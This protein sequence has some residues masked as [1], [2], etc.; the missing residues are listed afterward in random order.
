MDLSGVIAS[1]KTGTYTVTRASATDTYVAGRLAKGASTTLPVDA[2]VQPTEGR[3]LQKL[4]EGERTRESKTVFS[5]VELKGRAAGTRADV[6]TIN[7]DAYEIVKVQRW[8]ELGN[9][10]KAIALK[11]GD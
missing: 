10:W 1:F 3:D 7:G 5:A 11:V 9:Y 4:S 6:I 2:C 8:A